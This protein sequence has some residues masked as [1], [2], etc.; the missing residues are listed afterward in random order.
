M[1]SPASFCHH[2]DTEMHTPQ[3]LLLCIKL[4]LLEN[5]ISKKHTSE[6]TQM[7]IIFIDLIDLI[8][9]TVSTAFSRKPTWVWSQQKLF[10]RALKMFYFNPN[11]F[12]PA[13]DAQF[14]WRTEP[15]SFYYINT[16]HDSQEFIEG[17]DI[18]KLSYRAKIHQ[19]MLNKWLN[20]I[21]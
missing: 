2:F 3:Y 7:R 15:F 21:I 5:Y 18:K 17:R 13:R 1:S 14:T 4:N 6:K 8:N 9:L 11:C 10:T 20:S 12:P 16:S 19:L